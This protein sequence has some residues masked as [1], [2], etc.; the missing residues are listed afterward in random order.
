MKSD[1]EVK[2]THDDVEMLK[3][4]HLWSGGV[5]CVKRRAQKKK[6]AG[7]S[8]EA[9]AVV[10]SGELPLVFHSS[11]GDTKWMYASAEAAVAAGWLVD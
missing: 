7:S 9:Y 11:T 8:Y 1:D 4:P 3:R 10:N 5:L 6:K 2:A